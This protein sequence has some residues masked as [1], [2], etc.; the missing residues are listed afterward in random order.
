MDATSRE[1]LESLRRYVGSYHTSVVQFARWMELPTTDGNAL[2]E[3]LWAEAAGDPLSPTALAARVGITTGAT[4]ALINRLEARGLVQRS[5]EHEDRR[6]VTL[7]STA[8]AQQDARPFLDESRSR[9][10]SA[11]EDYDAD[12]LGLVREFIERL[13]GIL[14]H[15]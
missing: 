2:G 5:R 10:E 7:R 3:I 11:L 4:N 9:L 14:P 12:Q 15:S 1:V 6:V 8:S 13:A